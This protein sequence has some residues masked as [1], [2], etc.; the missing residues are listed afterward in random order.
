MIRVPVTETS[1]VSE[2]RRTAAERAEQCGFGTVDAGR[3]ALATTELASNLIKHAGGGDILVGGFDEPDGAGIQVLALD[4]GRGI[5][6]LAACRQDGYSTA[7]TNGHGLG[8]V[9]RQAHTVEVVSWPAL[10]TGLLAR[11][12]PGPPPQSNKPSRATF[13]VVSV[14][15]EG[16]S[17]CGDGWS[18]DESATARTLMVVDGLGHGP[19]AATAASEAVRVFQRHKGHRVPTMLDYIH[20]GLR[21]TRGAAVSIARIDTAADGV[22]FGGI[23]NV[24]GVVVT[25]AASRRMVSLPGTAGHIAR[26]I[27]SF[28]YPFDDGLVV[29]HSDGLSTSWSLDRYPGLLRAHP[30]LIAAVLFRDHWRRRDDV[31]VLVAGRGAAP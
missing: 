16:E 29:L 30:T 3:V 6:D 5:A 26:K 19:N 28:D 21:A 25:P 8:A 23:G 27:Q 4:K 20:G 9:F 2:A 31:T 18:V 24:S 13:G 14:A 1:Q 15:M 22:E 11:F 7:G 12:E 17:V 10:G